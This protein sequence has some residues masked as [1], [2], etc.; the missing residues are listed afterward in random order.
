[1]GLVEPN[2]QVT[3]EKSVNKKVARNQRQKILK[4]LKLDLLILERVTNQKKLQ[5]LELVS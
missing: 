5:K 2:N 4:A 1:M 3:D